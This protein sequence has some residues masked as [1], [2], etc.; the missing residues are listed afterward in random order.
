[1]YNEYR[2]EAFSLQHIETPV[3]LYSKK[4]IDNKVDELRSVLPS[5]VNLFY[6]VKANPNCDILHFI[7]SKVDG[8]EVASSGELIKVL[9]AGTNPDNIIYV[10]PGK[11]QADLKRAI[12][13]SV[14]CIVAESFEEISYIDQMAAVAGKTQAISVRVNPQKSI[15]S[16]R[17]K[18]GGGAKPF[19][20][21]EEMLPE[22]FNKIRNMH[23]IQ[24]LGIYVY[25]GTMITQ[26][27]AITQMFANCFRIASEVQ[28]LYENQFKMIGFGGGYGITYFPNDTSLDMERIK[29]GL[30]TIFNQYKQQF[31]AD[32]RFITESGRFLVADSG[33][34][35]V[36]VLY[37]K[38][39]RGVNYAIVDGGTN[40]FS[41]STGMGRYLRKNPRFHGCGTKRDMRYSERYTVV[42]PLCTPSDILLQDVEIGYVMAGDYIIF[43]K[44]GAYAFTTSPVNF[45]SHICPKEILVDN[46]INPGEE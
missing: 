2:I 35:I 21:D 20:I 38:K 16:A 28:H 15:S 10:G 33:Y 23:N 7:S 32:C 46:I 26:S 19:G 37:T 4:T 30:H 17:I 44:A 1:M 13:A 31:E 42:G 18:M 24:V 27:E 6:S 14:Y 11:T 43:P 36:K 45:L 25:S 9:R 34:Y 5:E 41:L 3:Y 22:L 8:M 40:F 29:S 39:S 12:S